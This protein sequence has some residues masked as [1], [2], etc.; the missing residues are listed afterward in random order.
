MLI[1]KGCLLWLLLVFL[2]PIARAADDLPPVFGKPAPA[3]VADLKAI[4]QQVK[5]ALPRLSRAV[6]AVQIGGASGS[7]VVIS[8]DGLV[9]TAAHVCGATNR[10]VRFTFPDGSTAR[11][12]TLGLNND[13]DAGMMRITTPGRWPHVD[14]G[15]L[16]QSHLG[17]WVVS[18]GHPGGFDPDRSL[19]VRLGRI[20]RLSPEMVQSD[21]PISAGDSGG[22]LFDMRGKVIGIHSRISD[23]TTENFHVPITTFLDTWDRLVKGESW[24]DERPARPWFGVRGADHPDGCEL[25]SV[26]EDSPAFKA[27]LKAGDILQKINN[28]AVQDYTMLKRLVAESKPG[29]VLKTEIQRD[30]KTLSLNVK[31]EART[32][33]R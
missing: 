3:S 13:T 12:K 27:G 2:A 31:I 7:G 5:A 18:L 16:H 9:L 21:C 22:P 1:D 10:D 24:G 23:S 17:D 32:G 6:V 33:R 14:V 4:E 11:G 19:V 28:R 8:E 26:E 25:L 15:D 20:I 30:E 29:D